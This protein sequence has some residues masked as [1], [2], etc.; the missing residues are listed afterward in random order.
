MTKAELDIAAEEERKKEEAE[1]RLKSDN[2][3]RRGLKAMYGGTELVMKIDRGGAEEDLEK[4]EW[5][6]KPEEEM[7]E[8]EKIK[9]TE[10]LQLL[11]ASQDNKT[12]RWLSELDKRR[13]EIQDEKIEFEEAMLELYK[14]RLFYEAR[15]YEQELYIVRMII[16]LHEKRETHIDKIKFRK[17]REEILF[18]LEDKQT[19][20]LNSEDYVTE[21]EQIIRSDTSIQVHEQ[22]VKALARKEQFTVREVLDFVVK[23]FS[24]ARV[25]VSQEKR[26]HMMK[27]I[28]ENDPFGQLDK[29]RVNAAIKIEEEDEKYIL[30]RDC[31]TDIT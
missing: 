25:Q 27:D 9:Y 21:Q 17:E 7:N 22:N 5:M 30:E 15:I 19:Y 13:K 26:D 18:K 11:K 29:D 20:L 10:F 2:V 28:V 14:K 3:G 12:R 24:R 6:N 31:P 1:A 8:E 23:G 4:E 16:M